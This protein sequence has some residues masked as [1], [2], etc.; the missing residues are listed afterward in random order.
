[1]ISIYKYEDFR[2]FLKDRYLRM[3]AK[4]AAFSYQRFSKDAGVRSPNYLKLIIDGTRNLTISNIHGFA[5]GL[6]LTEGEAE[7]FEAL[8]LLGQSASTSERKFYKSRI[9]KLRGSKIASQNRVAVANLGQF[10][11]LPAIL[12]SSTGMSVETAAQ[13]IGRRFHLPT[14]QVKKIFEKLRAEKI[15]D[16]CHGRYRLTTDYYVQY[17]NLRSN[18]DQKKFLKAQ[19]ELSG[20]ALERRYSIDAQ[21]FA[22]TF[23]T[24]PERL[25]G[26]IQ[27]IADLLETLTKESNDDPPE[28]AMQLNIQFFPLEQL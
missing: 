9:L 24:S 13:E 28:N 1:M 6:K 12:V 22:H 7:F 3:K 16:D 19:L 20:K 27:K 25:P 18:A 14:E 21:F 10:P 15:L 26:M 11:Y 17:D 23:T 2:E 4:D 8:V 5:R